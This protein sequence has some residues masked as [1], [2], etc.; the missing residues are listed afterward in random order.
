MWRVG[1]MKNGRFPTKDP[2]QGSEG[3]SVVKSFFEGGA[4]AGI[5]YK[6]NGRNYLVL[7]GEFLSS[8]PSVLNS[9]LAPRIR[10]TYIE[11][12]KTEKV[13]SVDLSY[14]TKYPFL[15]MRASLYFTQFFDV[16][17]VISFYADDLGTMANYAMT[18][19]N[20]RHLGAE[21]GAE[22]KL[23]SVLWLLMAGN[24]GDYRYSNTTSVYINAEN[25]YAIPDTKKTVCWKNYFVAGSP[26]VATTLGLKF[27]YKYWWVNINANYFD[28]IFCDLN[29]ERRTIDLLGN[30]DKNDPVYR[31]IADQ[32]RLK[33]QFTLDVSVSK[34]WRI[35]R[36]TVG[37]NV[38]ATNITNNK[39]LVTSGWEQYRF[40]YKE[41]NTEKFQNKYYYAFGTTFYAGFNFTFN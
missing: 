22:I 12:L 36:Y 17:K 24:F 29:P 31:Q 19:I 6:V 30:M 26:Q 41:L 16:S 21:L 23:C 37:F 35:K 38:S 34:S 7:N 27:N 13:T 14:V 9:F 18:G 33:G 4:K 39:N 11:N 25:G 28:R 1:F 15:K 8:A 10:N 5:T 40:D 2:K 32:T 20:K 3:K